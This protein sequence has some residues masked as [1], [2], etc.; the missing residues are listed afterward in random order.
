MIKYLKGIVVYHG[1]PALLFGIII[2]NIKIKI[3]NIY[4]K[5]FVSNK[6]IND[7]LNREI[8]INHWKSIR[9]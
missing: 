3:N 1:Y 2:S 8:F 5:Y 6:I 4:Y 9:R 7:K